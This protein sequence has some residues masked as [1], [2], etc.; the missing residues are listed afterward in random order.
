MPVNPL[1]RRRQIG[2]ALLQ[3]RTKR[4]LSHRGLADRAGISGS[5]ISRLEACTARPHQPPD[6]KVVVKLLD[7]LGVPRGSSEW[8]QLQRLAEEAAEDGWWDAKT[9]VTRMGEGQ[10]D[11]A[12][13]EYAARDIR[14]YGSLLV[15]GLAQAPAYAR[16]RILAALPPG[17]A[18]RVDG[19]LD[20]RASRQ[21]VI[22]GDNP[23]S[24]RLLLEVQAV[25]RAGVDQL[26][27]LLDLAD[28]PNI[29]VRVIPADARLAGHAPRAP[30]SHVTYCDDEPDIVVVDDVARALLVVEPAEIARY[31]NLW[32]RLS[33]A[34]MSED[35]TRRLI[36]ETAAG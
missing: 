23:A 5:T 9:T 10:R 31:A 4:G 32:D 12:L 22:L 17:E 24:Y 26:R 35:D 18:K 30:F 21:R 27:H 13:A 36:E 14:D 33:A 15:P 6:L 28:R 25:Y 2:D 11:Y 29:S 34:A 16:E 3:L 8:D 7:A 1:G 19:I 20:A